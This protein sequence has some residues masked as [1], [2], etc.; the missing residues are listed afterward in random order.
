ML[1]PALVVLDEHHQFAQYLTEVATV[2]FIND[3]EVRAVVVLGSL[4][5]VV[6][7][8]VAYHEAIL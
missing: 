4:A 3:E 7:D 8:T 2:D 6:E 1:R 5:E